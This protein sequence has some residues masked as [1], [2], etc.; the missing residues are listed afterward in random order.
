MLTPVDCFDHADFNA[1]WDAVHAHPAIDWRYCW[2]DGVMLD[3]LLEYYN[4]GCSVDETAKQTVE[5]YEIGMGE[6]YMSIPSWA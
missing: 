2:E 1:F 3:L 6:Y 4:K 5:D